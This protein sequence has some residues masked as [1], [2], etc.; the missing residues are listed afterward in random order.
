MGASREAT[1]ATLAEPALLLVLGALGALTGTHTLGGAL[2]LHLGSGPAVVAWVASLFALLVVVQ[3]E[4]ARMPVDDPATHLELTMIHEV[5]VLDHSGPEL[6]VIETSAAVKLTLGISII[7]ALLNP[8]SGT[9][10]PGAA[11][12]ANLGLTIVIAI[13]FGTVES[14]VAR[15][16]LRVVPRYLLTAVIAGGVALLATTWQGA[17]P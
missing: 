11:I 5:M 16:Q 12:A 3:A 14:L 13:L 17:I 8:W 6:A 10:H 2:G 9:A 1:Y 7:A 4:G 15:L